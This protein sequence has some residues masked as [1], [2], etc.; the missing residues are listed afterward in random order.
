M[1]TAPLNSSATLPAAGWPLLAAWKRTLTVVIGLAWVANLMLLLVAVGWILADGRSPQTPLEYWQRALSGNRY[2]SLALP[3]RVAVGVAAATLLLLLASVLLG[4]RKFRGLRSWLLATTTACCW[5][6]LIACWPTLY[7]QGQQARL[8]AILPEANQLVE[9]LQADWPTEDGWDEN[10]GAY[11]AYP[12]PV[13]RTL[14]LLGETQIPA[15]EI[16]IVCIEKSPAGALRLELG[17]FESG[18]WLEWRGDGSPPQ[19]YVG[20]LNTRYELVDY[21]P[22]AAGW[23]VVR[24][25]ANS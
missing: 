1:S 5:F 3:L 21:A 9:A 22:L 20:G 10:L 19:S 16:A 8:A 12:K 7:W 13:P 2:D 18:A 25:S 23:C 17:G 6:G 14:L 24:Y 4:P 15:T 11:M